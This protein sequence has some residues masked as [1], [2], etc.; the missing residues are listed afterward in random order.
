MVQFERAAGEQH[1]RLLVAELCPRRRQGMGSLQRAAVIDRRTVE[2]RVGTGHQ[3]AV[4][5]A[6]GGQGQ[7]VPGNHPPVG[8]VAGLAGQVQQQRGGAELA[9][10]GKRVAAKRQRSAAAQRATVSDVCHAERQRRVPLN[11]ALVLQAVR[12]HVQVAG[13]NIARVN[14]RGA[15]QRDLLVRKQAS[16]IG[17][18]QAEIIAAQVDAV[19]FTLICQR[20]APEAQ[21]TV[22]GDK[23]AVGQHGYVQR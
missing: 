21:C 3:P 19:D 15:V 1:A 13:R 10:V 12:R 7:A 11:G 23:P 18:G 20:V 8:I 22:G 4:R 16:G 6:G 17:V 2:P 14:Q 5:Q 9:A